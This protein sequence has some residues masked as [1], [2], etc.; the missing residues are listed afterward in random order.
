MTTK[1]VENPE[2]QEANEVQGF[3]AGGVSVLS[4]GS[5]GVNKFSKQ[6]IEAAV[7]GGLALKPSPIRHLGSSLGRPLQSQLCDILYSFQTNYL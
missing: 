1:N 4:G 5:Y 2:P 3:P 7:R 6:E